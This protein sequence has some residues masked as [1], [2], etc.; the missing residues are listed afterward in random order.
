MIKINKEF[1]Q[2][3]K[4]IEGEL[5]RYRIISDYYNKNPQRIEDN[6]SFFP[7]ITDRL[8][9]IFELKIPPELKKKSIELLVSFVKKNYY[10]K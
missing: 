3:I 6:K 8:I 5:E 7:V 4:K 2:E 10:L 1:F 9:D